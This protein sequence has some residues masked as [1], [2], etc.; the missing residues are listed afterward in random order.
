MAR[1]RK[2]TVT[3]TPT[4][5]TTETRERTFDLDGLPEERLVQVI[6]DALDRLGVES[7]IAVI[8]GAEERRRDKEDEARQ[9]LRQKFQ[10]E[11][12]AAGMSLESL[13]PELGGRYGRRRRADAGQPLQPTYRHPT[14][15]SLTWSGR[16]QPAKWLRDLEAGGHNREEFRIRDDQPPQ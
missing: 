8:R 14:D 4:H 11:A 9:R 1:G 13:F 12:T 15:P 6:Y 16:G 7:L 5:A 10:D 3:D 2:R